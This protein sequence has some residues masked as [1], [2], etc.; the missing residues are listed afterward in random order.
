MREAL[1][2]AQFVVDQAQTYKEAK[3][4]IQAIHY[5]SMILDL[6][7]ERLSE[8]LNRFRRLDTDIPIL[9]LS[10]YRAASDRIDALEAGAD[11]CLAKPFSLEELVVCTRVLLRRRDAKPIEKLHVADLELDRLRR[12]ATR[13]GKQIDLT[14]R[15]YAVLEYMMQNA[16][17]PVTRS[18]LME[19]VWNTN[20]EGFTNVV[21]VYISYLRGKIDRGFEPKLIHT[22]HGFGYVLFDPSPT[23]RESAECSSPI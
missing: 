1:H 14:S 9:A 10:T 5:D 22:A 3:D 13:R 8:E 18:M 7:V 20:F 4:L 2:G 11:E 6:S 17:R 12:K 21:D 19:H 15:E 23:A 16:G